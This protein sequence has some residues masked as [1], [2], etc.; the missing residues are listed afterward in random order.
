VSLIASH[1]HTRADLDHWRIC[2]ARDR[3]YLRRCGARLDALTVD[4]VRTIDEFS[5]AGPCY[6][7]VSWGK[8]ST[9]IAHLAH[10]ADAQIPLVWFPAGA[11]ENPDCTMVRDAFVDR[12]GSRYFEIS[13][14]PDGDPDSWDVT[15]EARRISGL[16]SDES[17]AR[18]LSAAVHGTAT[19]RS[20]RPIL[21]WTADDVFAYLSRHDLPVH[22]AYACTLGGT[23]DRGRVRV[24]PVGGERGAGRGRSEW[25]LRYYRQEI[26]ASGLALASRK[27]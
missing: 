6:V 12:F 9:V 8:D 13:V 2:E 26:A 14:P 11:I 16:R 15:T 10:L 3:E 4:A 23:L 19:A 24:G 20:C 1:R 7:S 21:R 27:P 25:E 18:A 22:P 5:A 17:T